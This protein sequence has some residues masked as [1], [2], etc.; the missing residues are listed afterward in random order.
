MQIKGWKRAVLREGMRRYGDESTKSI[1]RIV[2]DAS[3]FAL[4]AREH[5][6][7]RPCGTNRTDLDKLV[8]S[9]PTVQ[10]RCRRSCPCVGQ[11]PGRA[12]SPCLRSW[13]AATSP[14]C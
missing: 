1:G 10:Y 3:P 14:A 9:R 7:N 4:S 8:R 2:L 5:R 13:T 12:T 6:R 11:D